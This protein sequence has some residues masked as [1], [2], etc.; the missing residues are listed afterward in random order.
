MIW[1]TITDLKLKVSWLSAF[2]PIGIFMEIL[3]SVMLWVTATKDPATIPMR[4]YLIDAYKRKIDNPTDDTLN[5]VKYL[6]VHGPYLTK[7]KY[8]P[9]CDIFRPPRTIHCGLCG[10]CVERFDHHCPWI[11]TC[12]GKRN[13]KYF[14][15]FVYSLVVLM[16]MNIIFCSTYFIQ[17]D[18]DGNKVNYLLTLG[19]L[20][21]TLIIGIFVFYLCGYHQYILFRNETTNEN[22]KKSYAKLGNPFQRG[23]GDNISRLFRR[24][25]RNWRA[26]EEIV[27]FK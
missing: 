18:F 20:I 21:F 15:I 2:V 10:C 12:V 19:S 1:I 22:I 14:L 11:G 27:V 24:D 8:C 9:T 16:I 26:E 13:Y 25:K 7:M 3:T 23:V 5:R 4:D 6:A 17:M